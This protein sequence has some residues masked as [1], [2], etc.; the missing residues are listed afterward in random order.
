MKEN[1]EQKNIIDAGN[2]LEQQFNRL[3]KALGE[4]FKGIIQ[5]VIPIDS[6]DYYGTNNYDNRKGVSV[7]V[8]LNTAN[9]EVF[10]MF[11]ALPQD[12]RGLTKSNVYAFEKKYKSTP[13]KGL[14]VDVVL[15]ENGFFEIVF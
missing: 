12:V 14:E 8:K 7:E 6:K 15:N 1:K 10:T 4:G 13:K 11:F 2:E 5:K 9:G 3:E